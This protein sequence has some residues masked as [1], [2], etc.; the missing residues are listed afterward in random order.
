MNTVADSNYFDVLVLYDDDCMIVK[1]ICYAD[2]HFQGGAAVWVGGWQ[3]G[4]GEEGA[5]LLDEAGVQGR[6]PVQPSGRR[7]SCRGRQ[8]DRAEQLQDGWTGNFK[9][10]RQ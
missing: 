10:A 4:G 2:R 3:G 7:C 8:S 5:G 9:P 6:S 1:I